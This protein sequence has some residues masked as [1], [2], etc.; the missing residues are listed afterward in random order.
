M[1]NGNKGMKGNKGNKGYELAPCV[2]KFSINVD[3]FSKRLSTSVQ[4]AVTSFCHVSKLEKEFS[5]FIPPI[6][7][8]I[9]QDAISQDSQQVASLKSEL[10]DWVS[11]FYG[12]FI[13][14]AYGERVVNHA[15]S[16]VLRLCPSY[17]IH[18]EKF[19][20]LSH[21]FIISTILDDW[22]DDT[23]SKSGWTDDDDKNELDLKKIKYFDMVREAVV[24][25][26]KYEDSDGIDLHDLETHAINM[27]MIKDQPFLFVIA[28]SAKEIFKFAKTANPNLSNGKFLKLLKIEFVRC[29]ESLGW[30]F[31]KSREG[32]L[33]DYCVDTFRY[34]RTLEAGLPIYMNVIKMLENIELPQFVRIHPVFTKWH[35]IADKFV[36]ILNDLLGLQKQLLYGEE[37]GTVFFK[38]RKGLSLNDAIDDEIKVLEELVKDYIKLRKF[39]LT[40]FPDCKELPLYVEFVEGWLFG[41]LYTFKD[42]KQYGMQDQIRVENCEI[43]RTTM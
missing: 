16:Y 28:D 9:N 42:S 15:V 6:F 20:V 24:E 5:F 8:C 22:L 30:T 23:K 3:Q 38:V 31:V 41:S 35:E 1:E 2:V 27:E 12:S 14:P 37:D 18:S 33:D 17:P 13:K 7:Q 40:K 21:C 26:F 36:G 25:A 4:N 32:G 43:T 39:V 34:F 29:F 11:D 19:R 10:E